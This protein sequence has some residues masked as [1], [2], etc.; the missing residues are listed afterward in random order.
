M[1]L[2]MCKYTYLFLLLSCFNAIVL[3]L[4]HNESVFVDIV[5]SVARCIGGGRGA[6]CRVSRAVT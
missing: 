1:G 6:L 2:N 3:H 4:P 5:C